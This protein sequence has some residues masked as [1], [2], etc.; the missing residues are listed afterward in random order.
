MSAKAVSVL[1][2]LA[3]ARARVGQQAQKRGAC[4]CINWAGVYYDQ[5]AACGRGK[6]LYFLSKYG[7]TAAYAA[8]EPISGLPHKVCNDFFKNL[9]NNSCVNVDLLALSD[10]GDNLS[11]NDNMTDKQWCYVSNDC[12]VASLNG[13]EYATNMMGFQLGGWNNLASTSNLSWKICDPIA[14]QSYMLKYK[15]VQELIDIGTESDVGLSRLIRLAYPA[16]AITWAEVK[17]K[18]EAINDA[19][20]TGADLALLVDALDV[21]PASFTRAAEVHTTISDIIKSG[22]ATILD[23]PGHGDNFHVIKGREAWSVTR[24]ELGNMI[25]L[26]G[27]FSMEFD[28]TCLMGCA[29][30][31]LEALDLETQ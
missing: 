31:R 17:F 22:Q 29:T 25:Y 30:T 3:F 23:T 2:C 21:P 1:A 15:T 18:M 19:W 16:V 14:D 7:F 4:D 10:E 27:H 24:N 9:K 6:E 12:P 5:L 26:S 8:T 11:L 20:T 28:V 13:G